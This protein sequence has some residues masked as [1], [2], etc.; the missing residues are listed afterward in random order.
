MK[1]TILQGAFFPVPA[2]QGGAIEKAWEVLGQAFVAAGHTVTHISKRHPE[3]PDNEYI[4]AVHH[5]RVSGS[6][7]EGEGI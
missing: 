2:I 6:S 1:I 7:F 3:L 4:G 5:L